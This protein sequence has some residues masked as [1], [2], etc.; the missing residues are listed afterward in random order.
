[1]LIDSN[2]RNY[3]GLQ[4]SNDKS[5]SK[6]KKTNFTVK[7]S[8]K[9]TE[10]LIKKND[11]YN[12]KSRISYISSK[13]SAGKEVTSG[14]LAFLRKHASNLYKKAL[15][16]QQERLEYKRKLKE[17]K[18]KKEA[19]NVNSSYTQKG[20]S[21]LDIKKAN[22]SS[23]SSDTLILVAAIRDERE[24][25]YN[26][27]QY[28]ALIKAEIEEFKEETEH[29]FETNEINDN[30]KIQETKDEEYENKNLKKMV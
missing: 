20:I 19:D 25:F 22:S 12:R 21:A 28:Q 23:S 3:L 6:K 15:K 5:K 7:T 16:V 29:K 17:C 18:T 1:M 30:I 2:L 4:I 14:E 26:S 13:L 9:S 8:L 27:E 24:K 11:E 10:R